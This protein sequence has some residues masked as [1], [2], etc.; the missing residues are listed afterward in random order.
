MYACIDKLFLFIFYYF[1]SVFF[2]SFF[3]SLGLFN[4]VSVNSRL[5]N[6]QATLTYNQKTHFVFGQKHITTDY[7]YNNNTIIII[8]IRYFT[9]ISFK[10]KF[11]LA[12]TVKRGRCIR[13]RRISMREKW[14]MIFVDGH[15]NKIKSNTFNSPL[16]FSSSC[17]M[18]DVS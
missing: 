7:H 14:L 18:S 2:S 5:K 1:I 8:I 15:L 12:F 10:S 4:N 6:K 16:I 13:K 9:R 17:L 11:K 3:F